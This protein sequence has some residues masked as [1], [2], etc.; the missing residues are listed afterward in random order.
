M[1]APKV[2]A[3]CSCQNAVTHT[4]PQ[5]VADSHHRKELQVH[6]AGPLTW[7]AVVVAAR[8]VVCSTFVFSP[9]VLA[10]CSCKKCSDTHI[11]AQSSHRFTGTC[12]PVLVEVLK[13]QAAGFAFLV[14]ES[15]GC[16]NS[17]R[18]RTACGGAHRERAQPRCRPCWHRT[19]QHAD[20]CCFVAEESDHT[21]AS[22]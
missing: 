1:I 2:F 13:L 8:L 15:V 22:A 19:A 5:R 10:T 6:A 9:I 12:I 14:V 20:S 17:A 4:L 7:C 3:E 21:T 16:A 11:T 18:S